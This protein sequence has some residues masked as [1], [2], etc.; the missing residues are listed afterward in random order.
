MDL[1][2]PARRAFRSLPPI[3]RRQQTTL[4]Q[5]FGKKIPFEIK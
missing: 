1:A 2:D 4:E 3:H 5:S